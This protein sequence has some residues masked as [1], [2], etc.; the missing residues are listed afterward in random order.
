MKIKVG[1]YCLTKEHEPNYWL[2]NYRNK[3]V[4]IVE[5]LD[6]NN[7]LVRICWLHDTAWLSR[8]EAET[9]FRDKEKFTFLCSGPNPLFELLMR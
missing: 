2:S 8:G 1:D 6:T 7:D 5:I 4:K 3:L 9:F